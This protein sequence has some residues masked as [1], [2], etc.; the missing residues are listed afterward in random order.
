MKLFALFVASAMAKRDPLPIGFADSCWECNAQSL[1]DCMANGRVAQCRPT[2]QH[3][4]QIFSSSSCSTTIRQREGNVYFV[5]MGCKD[6]ESCVKQHECN[7]MHED[8]PQA[9]DCQPDSTDARYGSVCNQ[10][11]P[12]TQCTGGEIGLTFDDNTSAADWAEKLITQ[13]QEVERK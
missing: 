9:N 10:C 8:D 7:F 11:C 3:N 12:G 13:F 1:E 4:G 6:T 2:Q 5:S